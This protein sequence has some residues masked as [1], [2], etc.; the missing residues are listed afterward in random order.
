MT[1]NIIQA[2]VIARFGN[3]ALVE[4][5]NQT[6]SICKIRQK[7]KDLVAGDE[8]KLEQSAQGDVIIDYLPRRS[9]IGRGMGGKQFKPLAANIDSM[10]IV[11]APEPAPNLALIDSYLVIAKTLSIKPLLIINKKDRLSDKLNHLYLPYKKLDYPIIY[12]SCITMDEITEL[13]K[14]LQNHHA[15][16]VGPSGVGKSSLLK[17]LIPDTEVQI[18]SVSEASGEGR[19]TTTVATRYNLACGGSIIDSP[20]IRALALWPMPIENITAGFIEID[21]IRPNCKF[22][23][24]RH[25]KEPGC[26]VLAAMEQ[27]KIDKC[28]Y[29]HYVK[30]CEQYGQT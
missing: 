2:I 27:G 30:L 26:A 11:T 22:R 20:G 10:L 19:H 7:L 25:L 18:R 12:T 14:I 21:K 13:S 4:L 9:V 15:I 6:R 17:A 16:L 3:R 29:Q 8:V 5:S 28:R 1:D 23:N 24:C